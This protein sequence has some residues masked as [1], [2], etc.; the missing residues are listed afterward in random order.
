MKR[1]IDATIL[2]D[3]IAGILDTDTPSPLKLTY[4]IGI[5]DI[6]N[7]YPGI[8]TDIYTLCLYKGSI[9]NKTAATLIDHKNITLVIEIPNIT[10][11][12]FNESTLETELT[13]RT[14]SNVP[15]TVTIVQ[16]KKTVP[17]IKTPDINIIKN[18]SSK[19]PLIITITDTI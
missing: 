8:Y 4:Y 7:C 1:K 5:P 14:K 2:S 10:E 3:V 16:D 13:Y 18:I 6:E 15:I 9:F 12:T 11:I 19:S 17:T